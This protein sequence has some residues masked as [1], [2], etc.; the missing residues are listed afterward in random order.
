MAFAS[1]LSNC[2]RSAFLS[3]SRS[4]LSLSRVF[5]V[6]GLGFFDRRFVGMPEL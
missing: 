5:A 2:F 1:A 6:T 3:A 4:S